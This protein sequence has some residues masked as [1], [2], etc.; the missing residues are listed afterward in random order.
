M[1]GQEIIFNKISG[2]KHKYSTFM[3]LVY[4][5]HFQIEK[6]SLSESYFVKKN[7]NIKPGISFHKAKDIWKLHDI[8]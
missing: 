2:F 8:A 7:K 5:W 1:Q 3:K 4:I 6:R